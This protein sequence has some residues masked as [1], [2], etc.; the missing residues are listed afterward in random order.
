MHPAFEAIRNKKENV[1]S[2]RTE[3]RLRTKENPPLTI[4]QHLRHRTVESAMLIGVSAV[5][6][7]LGP[8][9]VSRDRSPEIYYFLIVTA[10]LALGVTAVVCCGRH[11][12]LTNIFTLFT[13]SHV[14]LFVARPTYSALTNKPNAFNATQSWNVN[15]AVAEVVAAG[16]LAF[17]LGYILYRRPTPTRPSELIPIDPAIWPVVRW[18]LIA[19]TTISFGL[20]ASYVARI[21]PQR[22][23][24]VTLLGR[25]TGLSSTIEGQTAYAYLGSQFGIGAAILLYIQGRANGNKRQA[26]IS[27]TLLAL[28]V[29]PQVAAGSRSG[30]IPVIV[31]LLATGQRIRP[32][33]YR[34]TRLAVLGVPLF[35]L[36]VVAPRLYRVRQESNLTLIE[37]LW[38]SAKPA[39]F[40]S[41][42]L[43]GLDTAMIDALSIQVAAQLQR[44]LPLA[45]GQTYANA[46]TAFIPRSIWPQKPITV[47]QYLNAELLPTLV[48]QGAGFSFSIYSEPYLNFGLIGV[49]MVLLALGIA[50]AKLDS[51]ANSTNLFAFWLYAMCAAFTFPI[52][53]G[54]VSFDIQRLM[55]AALPIGL[56]IVMARH[57]TRPSRQRP[58]LSRTLRSRP[59]KRG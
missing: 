1:N 54:S 26:W 29:F 38:E 27:L 10:S 57:S 16:Y 42:F 44:E 2:W 4:S 25:S 30:F 41:G 43:G 19:V 15:V 24:E 47:D 58:T 22:F 32:K 8:L 31:A 13:I 49:A 21:G 33:R 55:I 5:L 37:S 56:L 11:I 14:T 20:F 59:S 51:L 40:L 39:N 34:S 6:L 46:A 17:C 18:Q 50:A 36:T 52:F 53:R 48:G 35:L 28:C 7:A 9:L 3:S 12:R 45:I 23:L